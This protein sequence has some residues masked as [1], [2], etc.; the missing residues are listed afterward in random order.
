[1]PVNALRS[2]SLLLRYALSDRPCSKAPVTSNPLLPGCNYIRQ[3]IVKYPD[4]SILRCPLIPTWFA[5]NPIRGTPMAHS[6]S[7]VSYLANNPLL[8]SSAFFNLLNNFALVGSIPFLPSAD[9][10]FA[11]AGSLQIRPPSSNFSVSKMAS[12]T[13]PKALPNRA[14]RFLRG[15]AQFLVFTAPPP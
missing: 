12:V 1:M 15:S 2:P 14:H 3:A 7:N 11:Y 9:S 6:N 5:Q 8:S 13:I 4:P 10:L